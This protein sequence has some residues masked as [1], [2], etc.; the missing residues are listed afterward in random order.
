MQ[1]LLDLDVL[2]LVCELLDDAATVL[3]LSLASH[4]LRPAALKRLL[5]MRPVVLVDERSVRSFHEFIVA[6]VESRLPFV[7][8]LDIRILELEEQARQDVVQYILD[9]LEHATHLES[10]TLPRYVQMPCGSANSRS[11]QPA[12]HAARTWIAKYED[13]M[14]WRRLSSPRVPSRRC[15][16]S[17]SR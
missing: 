3:S 17:A 8:A 4:T 1:Q 15:V 7:R 14:R 2:E 11:Y 16:S 5:R 10:L 12:R 9:L 6:D 13:A